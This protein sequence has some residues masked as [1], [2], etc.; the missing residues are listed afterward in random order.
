LPPEF[1]AIL[2]LFSMVSGAFDA[3]VSRLRVID[4][5]DEDLSSLTLVLSDV[6]IAFALTV[7]LISW[8]PR[9]SALGTLGF[10][11]LFILLA[12]FV[13]LVTV[14][15][16]S[17]AKPN[18]AAKRVIAARDLAIHL[19]EKALNEHTIVSIAHPDGRIA[20]VNQNF[21]ETSAMSRMTS[22][23]C[24]P[25]HL[26]VERPT[27]NVDE[28]R[29]LVNTGRTW[30][31]TQRLRTKDDRC[32]TVETTILPRFDDAGKFENSISIRTD[33]SRAKA[34][35]VKKGG[36]PSSRRCPTRSTSTTPRHSG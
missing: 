6:T 29:H 26:L 10:L 3:G 34:Q 1:P 20:A 32:L 8:A 14:V 21:V 33:V 22:S 12:A 16:L 25:N 15:S 7:L 28:L 23:G 35:G 30:K 19:R 5:E 9:F 11:L 18:A 4:A 27:A 24:R 13:A 31:G 36:T 2:F 17:F